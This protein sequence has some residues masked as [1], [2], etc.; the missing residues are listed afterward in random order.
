MPKGST[1]LVHMNLAEQLYFGQYFQIM[2][3]D[4]VSCIGSNSPERWLDL[5]GWIR[6]HGI[7]IRAFMIVNPPI[8]RLMN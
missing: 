3:S 6:V 2:N 8:L 5:H 1:A 7:D 4:G